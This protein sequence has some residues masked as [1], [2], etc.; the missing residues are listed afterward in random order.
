MGEVRRVRDPLLNRSMAMKIVRPGLLD[1][2]EALARFVEEAQATA[3]LQHPGIVPVHELGRLPDGR[4]FFTMREVRGRTLGAVISEVHRVSLGEW[5]EAE[6]GW[7]FRRL[8]D[9]FHRACEAV[10]Y[11]HERAVVHRDLKP[12]NV[13]VGG[14]GEVL[15]VDW[16]L[17][18]VLGRPAAGEAP[19][20]DGVVLT[21]R[22][23]DG[24]LATQLGAVAG[25]PA[26]MP[27]EQARGDID[28]IDARS[29]VYA[30][31]AILYEIL[32]GRPP[33]RGPS[34]LSVV[35]QVLDGP[36]EPP[37][38][39]APAASVLPWSAPSAAE[40]DALTGPLLPAELVA[41]CQRAMARD[42]AERFPDASSLAAEAGAWLD[43]LRRRDQ[44]LAVVEEALRKRPQVAALRERAAAVRAEAKA[45][46]AGVAHWEDE[47]RK[48]PGWA[49]QAQ[50]E[51][52]E[53]RADLLELEEEQLLAA[54]LTHHPKLVEAHVALAAR[55]R[56][57]HEACEAAGQDTAR[58]EH[59]LRAQLACLPEGN[60]D[61]VGHL[62]WLRGDGALRLCSDPPGAEVLLYRYE[63]P[64]RRLVPVFQRSLGPTPLTALSLPFGSYL[65]V[66]RAPGHAELRY[67]VHIGRGEHWNAVPPG[68]PA[69]A[70]IRLLPPAALGPDDCYVPAGW[71][72]SGG[73]A[74]AAASLPRRRRWC[75]GFVIRRFAV[76][77]REYIAFLDDLVARGHPEEA[78]ALAPRERVGTSQDVG[79]VIYGFEDGRFHLRPDSDG[80]L[81]LPDFPV[82]MIDQQGALAYAAWRAERD[83]L[84]WQ[85]PPELAWEKAARGVDGRIHPWG[86]T[87]DPSWCCMRASHPGPPSPAVVDSFPV[88]DSPYGVRGMCGGVRER[89][90]DRYRAEGPE[91][92]EGRV[93]PTPLD[94]DPEQP[95][96]L[97]GGAWYDVALYMRLASRS[98][99]QPGQRDFV[100]GA[101]LF[102]WLPS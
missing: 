66:L 64:N 77:N 28:H 41:A 30:L 46:L 72:W 96:T 58:A 21:H 61:R 36:P 25:T 13:M 56:A 83:G 73:D 26:Y 101:R 94:V 90:A 29:D 85:L 69:P 44:A 63:R 59:L 51:A 91:V 98:V 87:L 48:A 2:P 75:E 97:K 76:T 33:Y 37:G 23:Q 14:H 34:P 35:Q 80:D 92:A 32:S 86:D 9:A 17:A 27:P 19:G 74:L 89:C 95:R 47:A 88:D 24:A 8:I 99:S 18:K 49:R 5:S 100:V 12:S 82:M 84:P 45:L 42:P 54:A 68:A 81:W 43:G 70:P 7:T 102:R 71:F 20:E 60:P 1:Q 6:G 11:A 50:A 39:V 16:G 65:C 3:Q 79:P 15:V 10:A 38:P 53:E 57:A 67:P 78:L 93:A 52:L 55:Y 4:L 22:S 31:G 40:P 62:A